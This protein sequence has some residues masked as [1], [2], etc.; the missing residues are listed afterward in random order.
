MCMLL[1]A[2]STHFKWELML[3]C[4]HCPT[5]N[6]VFLLLL[7]HWPQGLLTLTA[8]LASVAYRYRSLIL[9]WVPVTW[10][11][12]INI[13]QV[14]LLCRMADMYHLS[15][16]QIHVWGNRTHRVYSVR[17][18]DACVALWKLTLSKNAWWFFDVD[19]LYDWQ[20]VNYLRHQRTE[21]QWSSVFYVEVNLCQVYF[22]YMSTTWLWMAW[23]QNDSD[24]RQY[25]PSFEG[26]TRV[27]HHK[28]LH[29]DRR[30]GTVL[31]PQ[32]QNARTFP[33]RNLIKIEIIL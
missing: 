6:K 2:T 21:W 19:L 31:T 12:T 22:I 26:V 11:S 32:A 23:S 17:C 18:A 29:I 14:G 13:T 28:S 27:Q 10:E 30:N 25:W 3:Y 5:L 4:L 16:K 8:R 9:E 15:Y 7:L 33:R 20:L 1:S 24:L